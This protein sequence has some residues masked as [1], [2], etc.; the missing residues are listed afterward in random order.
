MS[1]RLALGL[2]LAALPAAATRASLAG[3]VP[4]AGWRAAPEL[5]AGFPAGA[6]RALVHER[7]AGGGVSG[8]GE[9]PA[10]GRRREADRP[11]RGKHHG[12]RHLLLLL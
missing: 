1:R 6:L 4:P 9:G 2:L 10:G 7:A 11:R 3:W 8:G 5:E 12:R